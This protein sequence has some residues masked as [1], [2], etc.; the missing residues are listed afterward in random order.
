MAYIQINLEPCLLL[1]IC[2]AVNYSR[3]HHTQA[4]HVD[5][6][7]SCP[8]SGACTSILPNDFIQISLYPLCCR[9]RQ[10]DKRSSV[11]WSPAHR[12]REVRLPYSVGALLGRDLGWISNFDDSAITTGC[13]SVKCHGDFFQG[14]WIIPSG[15]FPAKDVFFPDTLYSPW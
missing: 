4:H 12:G 2:L 6:R 13:V 1:S 9:T 10:L 11:F 7:H 8:S 14:L 15:N 3:L 5:T